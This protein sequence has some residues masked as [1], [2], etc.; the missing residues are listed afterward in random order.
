ML[1]DLFR[2]VG[3][4]GRGLRLIREPGVRPY[5]TTPIGLSVVLFGLLVVGAYYGFDHAMNWLLPPSWD[6]LRALLWPLFAVA[7]LVVMVYG[8]SLTANIVAAPFN[9]PLAAAAERRVRGDGTLPG[10]NGLLGDAWE[11]LRCELSRLRYYLVRA[12]PALLLFAVP[13]VNIAAPALWL[14]LGAWMLGIEYGAYPMDNH[15]IDFRRQRH[16]MA[17]RPLLTLGFGGAVLF[18]GMVPVLNFFVM[19]A[20]VAGAT[21]MWLERFEPNQD[22]AP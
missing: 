19:P 7:I 18:A 14:L 9:G 20:A 1:L 17:Q 11:A 10:G 5:A 2:G 15:R 3:Y 21:L 6:W 4:L 22:S 12:V 8:F 16:I 13:V